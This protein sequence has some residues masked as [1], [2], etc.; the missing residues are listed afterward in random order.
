MMLNLFTLSKQISFTV[1]SI[2][3]WNC[4]LS[5]LLNALS[6]TPAFLEL[7]VGLSVGLSSLEKNVLAN[8]PLL[9]SVL[10]VRTAF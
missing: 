5:A 8:G 6:S 7:C 9:K 4:S 2:S 10:A 1:S 3:L